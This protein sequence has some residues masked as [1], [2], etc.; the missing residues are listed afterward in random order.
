MTPKYAARKDGNQTDIVT[1]LRQ[2]GVSV[3][4]THTLGGG[5]GDIVCGW[6]GRNYVFEIK[7]PALP[8]Y[9]RR[10]T[11]DEEKWHQEWGGQVSII[12]TTEDALKVM[13][14][15]PAGL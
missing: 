1:S 3:F 14:I 12:L 6:M 15:L 11:K 5:F 13:G 8:P 4:I 10:L 7:D 9:H 2:C